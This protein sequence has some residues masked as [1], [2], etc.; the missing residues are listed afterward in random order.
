MKP[1]VTI[2]ICVKN[3]E[4][5]IKEAIESI[6]NQDFPPELMELIIVDGCSSDKTLSIVKDCLRGAKFRTKIFTEKGGLGWQRQI[7]VENAEGDYILWVDADMILPKD[8]IKRQVDFMEKNPKVG[9]AKGIESLKNVKGV[10]PTLEVLSRSVEKMVNHQSSKKNIY[11]KTLGTGG[12][13]YRTKIIRDVGGFDKNLKYYCEDWDIEVRVR[14]SGWL[15]AITDAE[16]FDYERHGVTW[17]SL[18]KKYWLRGY[19]THYFLHKRPGL[20]RHYRMF[21]PAA[22]VAGILHAQKLFKL[23]R[24]MIVFLL[25]LQYVFKSAAWYTGFITSHLHRYEPRT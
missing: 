5:T 18:W 2:G 11:S 3:A 23:L 7:V 9:I 10:L 17:K 6:L 24:K 16:Y 4:T 12:S 8:H 20:I 13:I 22:L 14:V 15:L 21:P 19:Y 1:K 25:P